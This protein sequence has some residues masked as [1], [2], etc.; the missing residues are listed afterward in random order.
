MIGK[1]DHVMMWAK[2]LNRVAR[3]YKDKLGF[4]VSYH[5]PGEFLSMHHEVAGRLDFHATGDKDASNVG[6]GPLP[7]YHVRDIAKTVAWLEGKGIEVN[8]VQ[9]VSDSP[10]HTWFWDCEG[11]AL[12][13]AEC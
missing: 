10:K 3:W 8:P 13:I 7:Y 2:D 6:K 4:E 5:A 1:L 11:N 9:Q 12:G